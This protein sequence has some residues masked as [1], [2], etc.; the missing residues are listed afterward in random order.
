MDCEYLDCDE[1][2]PCLNPVTKIVYVHLVPG[3]ADIDPLY[4][5]TEHAD[6]IEA[7]ESYVRTEE[8]NTPTSLKE[9]Q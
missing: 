7:E 8:Y 3:R 5:C 4:L 6:S 2:R 9:V 1:G